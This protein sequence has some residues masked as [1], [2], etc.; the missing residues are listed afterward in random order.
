[1]IDYTIPIIYKTIELKLEVNVYDDNFTPST[2]WSLDAH[3]PFLSSYPDTE[4]KLR[5]MREWKYTTSE[6]I[7]RMHIVR[8]TYVPHIIKNQLPDTCNPIYLSLMFMTY[9]RY[10]MDLNDN[11]HILF[12]GLGAKSLKLSLQKT[13]NILN[14]Q[15]TD[16]ITC[17]CSRKVSHVPLDTTHLNDVSADI[18]QD[19]I[20]SHYIMHLRDIQTQDEI[21]TCIRDVYNKLSTMSKVELELELVDI[22]FNIKLFNYYSSLGFK[23]LVPENL[24]FIPMYAYVKDL[25]ET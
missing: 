25:F 7:F 1:M 20:I 17:I 6:C 19:T 16:I 11:E 13:R 10:G 23:S 24:S 14:I 5:M 8:G 3:I 18:I 12:K 4:Y 22:E 15:D 21:D 9:K 2:K